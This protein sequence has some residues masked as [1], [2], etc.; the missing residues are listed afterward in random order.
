MNSCLMMRIMSGLTEASRDVAVKNSVI[1]E[2]GGEA[3]VVI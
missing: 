1:G 2:S 3:D